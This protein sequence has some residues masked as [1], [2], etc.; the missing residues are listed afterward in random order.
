MS[1]LGE[2]FADPEVWPGIAGVVSQLLILIVATLIALRFASLTIRAALGRLFT[3]EV[4][5]G[6]AR[7]AAAIEVI[8]RRETLDRLL[9]RVFVVI[10]LTIAFVMALAI[11]RLDIGPAIAGLGVLGLALSLGAQNLVRDYVAGAFV[12]AENQYV[13]GDVV[14][15]AG[16]TGAVEDVNL[17]RT[18]L[19][20]MDGTLHFVPHGLVET[21]SNLTRTQVNV[22]IDLPVPYGIDLDRLAAAIDEAGRA[23]ADDPAWKDR[24]LQAPAFLRVSNLGEYGMTVKALGTVRALDRWAAA[25]EF[26]SRLLEVAAREGIPLGWPVSA[27]ETLAAQSDPRLP[28]RR[29]R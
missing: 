18:T 4:E 8:R 2:W 12:F 6:T 15:I 24:V 25:G 20:D 11:L 9:E 7:D 14:S 17:R 29:N 1:L 27:G 10:I 22:N 26:R 23:L 3:R 28:S 16:V 19:R 13:R 21:S 5:E